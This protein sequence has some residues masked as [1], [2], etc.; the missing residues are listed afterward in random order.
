M[1]YEFGILK[2][3]IF[4]TFRF[5][6]CPTYHPFK[7]WFGKLRRTRL[8]L[9]HTK[10]NIVQTYSTIF[11][12]VFDLVEFVHASKFGMPKIMSNFRNFQDS[13]ML[14]SFYHYN[15]KRLLFWTQENNPEIINMIQT[16]PIDFEKKNKQ[17]M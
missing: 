16:Y 1:F 3:F 8:S 10:C 14:I 7:L 6:K 5:H 9:T 15:V 4:E 11:K 17:T 13:T 12:H 2:N